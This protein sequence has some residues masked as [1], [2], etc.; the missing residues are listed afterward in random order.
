MVDEVNQNEIPLAGGNVNEQVV[1]TGDTVRRSQSNTSPTVHK[2]LEHLEQNNFEGAPR[3]L[4]IDEQ[5]REVLS[6]LEGETGVPE[7]LW[8]EDQPIIE[9]AKL[10]KRY[11]DATAS[12]TKDLSLPWGIV[13]PDHNRHEVICHNDFA[14]YNFIYRSKQPYAVIDFDLIGP[15]PRLRDIAYAAYWL[16]PLSFNSED[17]LEYT[18]A[19]INN[20]NRRLRLFCDT[21][22]IELND[23]LLDMLYEVLCFMGDKH[24]VQQVIGVQAA[25]KLESDGHLDHCQKEA[26]AF[27]ENRNRII[28]NGA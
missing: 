21:Y 10:L 5:Q 14:P 19:D 4:G 22:G 15:G 9:C 18:A 27:T 16:T 17:M 20:G 3:F 24:Q 28:A 2:L 13:Y 25:L 6:Y 23:E 8:Q 11:H 26:A 1:R 12:F 7:Y